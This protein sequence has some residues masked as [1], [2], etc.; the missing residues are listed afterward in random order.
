LDAIN[1]FDY[2]FVDTL[3]TASSETMYKIYLIPNDGSEDQNIKDEYI[4]T[5]SGDVYRWERF[6]TTAVSLAN[7]YTIAEA[8]GLIDHKLDKDDVYTPGQD[9]SSAVDGSDDAGYDPSSSIVPSGTTD[10]YATWN[11]VQSYIDDRL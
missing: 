6:G 1:Q 4:T 2:T 8:Q 7:Y 9:G 5:K 10:S 11:R 3:P